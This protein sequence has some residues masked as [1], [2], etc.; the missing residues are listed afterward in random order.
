MVSV[1]EPAPVI[2]GGL[3]LPVIAITPFTVAGVAVNV[4]G[5]LNPSATR[6]L[7]TVVPVVVVDV[8]VPW[9]RC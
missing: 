7:T 2:V 9:Q 8:P 4:T 5:E 6:M 1:D 3:K